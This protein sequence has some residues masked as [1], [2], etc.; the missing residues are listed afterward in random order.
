LK[1]GTVLSREQEIPNIFKMGN[2]TYNFYWF[3]IK[4]TTKYINYPKTIVC[5]LKMPTEEI[6]L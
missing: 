3:F 6:L 5:N 4:V 1:K 2:D